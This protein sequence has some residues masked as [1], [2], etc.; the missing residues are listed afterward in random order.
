LAEAGRQID[1]G[2]QSVRARFEVEQAASVPSIGNA[3]MEALG[4]LAGG[5]AH[6]FNNILTVMAGY[7]GL[8]AT[9]LPADA[10]AQSDV[11]EIRKAAEHATLLTRQL[12]AFGRREARTPRLLNLTD[13][14]ADLLPTLRRLTGDQVELVTEAAET[15]LVLADPEQLQHVLVN[16]IL[17]SDEA[18]PQGGRI[19]IA[20]ARVDLDDDFVAAHPG[21]RRGSFV[22]LTVADTGSGIVPDVLAHIFEPYFTTKDRGRGT[23]LGLA[24]AYGIVIQNGGCIWADSAVGRG[25]TVSICLPAN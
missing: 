15:P 7:A 3:Q 12:L 8:L 19:A 4:R 2:G 24:T 11:A 5:I 25:T 10:P 17:N 22:R 9:D 20:T 16:L 23:G 18:M 14:V 1:Q 21:S 6:D 13:V